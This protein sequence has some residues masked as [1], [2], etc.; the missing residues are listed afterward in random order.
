MDN[1]RIDMTS[2]L[3]GTV[4]FYERHLIVCSGHTDWPAKIETAGGFI[5]ALTTVIGKRAATI[6]GV[7]R[8]TAC[9]A[10]PL[11]GG[12][13]VLLYPEQVRVVG[14]TT[15]DIPALIQLLQGEEHPSLKQVT[16]PKPLFLVCAHR[17]RDARCGQ[18]GPA[19]QATFQRN[20]VDLGLTDK[21]DVWRSSHLGGHHF[22]GIVVCY[23]SGNWYGRITEAD[24]PALI[25]TELQDN[26]AVA[27]LW[28]GRM[29]LMIDD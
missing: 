26:D 7:V 21:V 22:A 12:T 15:Q 23:P 9:E 25:A 6:P 4:K 1:L 3:R 11:A 27:H 17:A 28:R 19:L 20:L 24:I 8:V 29:G 5:T 16:S 10:P 18:C 13:D 2:P 14:L